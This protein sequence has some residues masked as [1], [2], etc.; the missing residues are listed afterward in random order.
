M[1][2]LI[3]LSIAVLLITGPLKSIGASESIND[4]PILGLYI[5][6]GRRPD[7]EG[8]EGLCRWRLI[9]TDSPD[10]IPTISMNGGSNGVDGSW[11]LNLPRGVLSATNPVFLA[12][13]EGKTT[14]TFPETFIAPKEFSK[15]LG[16]AKDLIIKGNTS[17]PV[18]YENGVFT[19]N[20][21]L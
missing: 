7:C 13:L 21:P 4:G 18:V 3:L 8:S 17:Y 1:K 5:E 11:S 6:W 19:I 20:F 2:I 12:K 9:T 10:P 14:V 16:T 15:A